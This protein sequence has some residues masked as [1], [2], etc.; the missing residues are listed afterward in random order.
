MAQ[1]NVA[2]RDSVTLVVGATGNL[3]GRVVKSLLTRGKR[4]RALVREG[5]DPSRL[6]A[7]GVEIVRGD[8]LDRASLDHAM[9]G[10]SALVTTAIGYLRRRKG[11]SLASVDDRGNRNLVDA[12]R[13]ARLDRFVFTSILTCDKARNVPHFWQKKIIEDYLEASGVPF[14]SLRPGAFFGGSD[15]WAK[16]LKKGRI[17]AF[18]SPTTR[19]SSIAVDD[20][21]RYLAFAV[22]E[23]RAV[24]H[25][26]DLGMDGRSRPMT[27]P[28]LFPSSLAAKSKCGPFPGRY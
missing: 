23:P 12:A 27:W 3:G 5:T 26:I 25:R 14:V 18:G 2:E 24:G 21:A 9:D 16:D 17:M 22:E 20:V 13:S 19:W 28:L 1:Q 7:Q 4:V 10:A 11:D 8:M 15:F 6:A